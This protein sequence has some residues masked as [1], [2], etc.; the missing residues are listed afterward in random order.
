MLLGPFMGKKDIIHLTTS[1]SVT[2]K[3]PEN[4]K[5]KAG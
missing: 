1:G 4:L 3:K 5:S 2:I